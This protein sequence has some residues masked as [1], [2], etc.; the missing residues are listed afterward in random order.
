[1][2]DVDFFFFFSFRMAAFLLSQIGKCLV[3]YIHGDK[4]HYDSVDYVL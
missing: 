1:M 3:S 4:H 2:K